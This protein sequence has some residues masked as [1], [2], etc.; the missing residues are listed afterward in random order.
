MTLLQF[1]SILATITLLL[2]ALALATG[3]MVVVI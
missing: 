2:I 1:A 3:R